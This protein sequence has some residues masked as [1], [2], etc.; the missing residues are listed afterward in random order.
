MPSTAQLGERYTVAPVGFGPTE[1]G[2]VIRVVPTMMSTQVDI[3]GLLP[4]VI[5]NRGEFIQQDIPNCRDIYRV[6]L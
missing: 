6:R 1:S 3:P 2:Y 5:V 4:P